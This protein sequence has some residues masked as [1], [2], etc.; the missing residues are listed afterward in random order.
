M[1]LLVT[2]DDAVREL[3][4]AGLMWPAATARRAL[5]GMDE[6]R[7]AP[8]PR[9]QG[10]LSA[11]W[12]QH[13]TRAAGLLAARRR[14]RVVVAGSGRVG[15]HLVAVLAASGVG[16]VAL[17]DASPTRLQH[18]CPGGAGPSDEGRPLD[19]VAADA[20]ERAAPGVDT[21]APAYGVLPDVLVL[22]ADE[23]LDGDRRQALQVRGVPHLLV[24]C[25]A[26]CTTVGP[27]VVPGA[28]SCLRCADLHRRDRDPAW[29]ALAVQ[30]SSPE[31]RLQN[32]SLAAATL[33]VALAAAQILDYLDGAQPA[34]LG[35]TLEVHPPD[36][37]VRRRSWPVHPECGCVN[38]RIDS[39][40]PARAGVRRAR[41][42]PGTMTR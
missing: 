14:R 11:M 5:D 26:A 27:L 34:T 6:R 39:R 16:H 28:T 41:I 18:I 17:T 8:S 22:A 4:D 29:S 33:T 42:P 7:V 30:L 3:L 10:E 35:A 15:P 40:L 12:V 1:L 37:R 25:T 32:G 31:R 20:A 19:A 9:L 21:A 36:W 38:S 24:S 23:L 13:G 2:D